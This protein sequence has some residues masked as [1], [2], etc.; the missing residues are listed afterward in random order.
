MG[1]VPIL[2]G[3]PDAMRAGRRLL[4]FEPIAETA[5]K[6]QAHNSFFG[7]TL[8]QAAENT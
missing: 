5:T 1:A 8:Q 4:F 6:V 2:F 3:T 7:N